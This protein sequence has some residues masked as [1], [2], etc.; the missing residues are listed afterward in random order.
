MALEDIINK[1]REKVSQEVKAI[2]QEADGEKEELIRQTEQE[3]NMLKDELI[4]RA[5]Q[6][7]EHDRQRRLM[8]TRSE[9]RKKVLVLK[10][11]MVDRVF[12]QAKERLDEVGFFN[13]HNRAGN[14]MGSIYL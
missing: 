11:A 6:E 4:K 13:S 5:G 9:E 7:G 8:R 14:W 2:R 1:I 3:A 12:R 10:R